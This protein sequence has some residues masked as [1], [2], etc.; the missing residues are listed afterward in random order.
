MKGE[1]RMQYGGI[2]EFEAIE[3]RM[4]PSFFVKATGKVVVCGRVPDHMS[5]H[6]QLHQ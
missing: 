4:N 1:K 3:S 6:I 2:K 5:L